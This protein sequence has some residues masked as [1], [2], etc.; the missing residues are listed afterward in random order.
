MTRG[1][2]MKIERVGMAVLSAALCL[3]VAGSARA[4]TIGQIKCE[5]ARIKAFGKM[6]ACLEKA[7]SLVLLGKPDIS[8]SCLSKYQSAAQK[9]DL[10]AGASCRYQDNG[11]GTVTDLDTGLM[12][13]QKAGTIGSFVNCD[14]STCSNPHDVN[15][16]YRWSTGSPY[17]PTG[18]AFTDFLAKL[19]GGT[20]SD[21]T[22]TSGCF[23]GHCDW[24][25]PTIEELAGIID[26]TQGQCAGGS[27]AC[28]D[29]A[30][31]PT[32]AGFY[33]SA[34]TDAGNPGSAWG[35][36]FFGGGVY[37]GVKTSHGYVR[38]VRGGL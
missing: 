24:R 22:A 8:P 23:A 1:D 21:G 16:G 2:D 25:L 27:G 13:E 14:T 34:T 33:W 37:D 4:A 10:K 35:A 9:A 29:P 5:A 6:Q 30:F 11:D 38:A 17:D 20:S 12:W 15:N 31:S 32:Q 36:T 28:I 3:C 7:K 19:N 26:M 18:G